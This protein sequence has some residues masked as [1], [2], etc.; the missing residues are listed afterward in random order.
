MAEEGDDGRP[1]RGNR[2]GRAI[3]LLVPLVTS[4][5]ELITVL[6]K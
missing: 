6:I 1:R 4:V 2:L 5:I 3:V